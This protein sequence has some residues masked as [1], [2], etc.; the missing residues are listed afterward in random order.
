MYC[1]YREKP[2]Q[3]STS[4]GK[5]NGTNGTSTAKGQKKGS[6]GPPMSQEVLVIKLPGDGAYEPIGRSCIV[7]Y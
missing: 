5:H 4:K 6:R 3:K 2:V 7:Y 1:C